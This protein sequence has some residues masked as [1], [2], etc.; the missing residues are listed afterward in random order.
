MK[1]LFLI[2][3]RVVFRTAVGAACSYV[4]GTV[5]RKNGCQIFLKIIEAESTGS[6][7][8]LYGYIFNNL[9]S[10]LNCKDSTDNKI[11]WEPYPEKEKKETAVHYFSSVLWNIRIQYHKT[12]VH[13]NIH[14][15]VINLAFSL[16]SNC[17]WTHAFNVSLK[18]D[19]FF[20]S[21]DN[22]RKGTLFCLPNLD[23]NSKFW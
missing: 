3:N 17:S 5:S 16:L 22:Y 19:S 7:N 14:P 21:T 9:T 18:N 10:L 1:Y 15:C 12:S 6:V 11:H 20:S 8:I 2:H 4:T 23:T 13:W